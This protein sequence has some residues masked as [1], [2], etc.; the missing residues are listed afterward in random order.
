[1]EILT[2]ILGLVVI[3]LLVIVIRLLLQPRKVEVPEIQE[4]EE[5]LRFAL[6]SEASMREVQNDLK[7]LPN[8]LLFSITRSL[9]KRTGKLNELMATFELT[10]YD[11]L[12]YLGD[13]IDFIGIKYGE[14]IDFIEVKTGRFSLTKDEKKLRDLIEDGM[15]NYVPLQVERIGIAEEVDLQ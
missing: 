13:P 4:M 10:Q 3:I 6:A 11:R 1:M 7:N 2:I 9:G 15:V 5:K 14:G 12:F 8:Q